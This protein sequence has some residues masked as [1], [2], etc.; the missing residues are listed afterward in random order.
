MKR[1]TVIVFVEVFLGPT[2]T[3]VK[4]QINELRE[5]FNVII[6]ANE[7]KN[8]DLFVEDVII[9][10]H[11]IVNRILS[12]IGKK[13]G[14]IYSMPPLGL[15]K[16]MQSLVKNYDVACVISHFGT[17]GLQMGKIA[18]SLSIPHTIIIHGWDGSSL[19][20]SKAY[21]RQFKSLQYSKLLF[22]SKSMMENFQQFGLLN[23]EYKV[24]HLGIPCEKKSPSLRPELKTL[25]A[26]SS[27]IRFFQAANFVYKKGHEYSISAFALFLQKYPNAKFILAG[28]GPLKEDILDKI[29]QLGIEDKVIL[30]GHIPQIDVLNWFLNVDIFLHHSVTAADG[31]QESIPSVIMEAM[32]YGLPVLSTFHSGIPELI[33]SGYDGMLV[34]EKNIEDYVSAI[35]RLCES[36]EK[37]GLNGQN[38]ILEKFNLSVNLKNIISFS[39]K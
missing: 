29:R 33:T 28:D 23:K 3:F 9:I 11:D 12:S 17:A 36:D 22:V 38:T 7:L 25:F 18:E 31:D 30:L 5:N 2:M 4:N 14:L 8:T 35:C 32:L 20:R 26:S 34:Q 1:K 19:L 10:P 37:I 24:I 39:V 6:I 13:T 21:R 16:T 15:R 27:E